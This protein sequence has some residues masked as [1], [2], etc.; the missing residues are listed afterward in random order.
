MH[1]EVQNHGPGI[2]PICGMALEP[3]DLSQS[4]NLPNEELIDMTRRFKLSLFF[5][6]PLLVW[7]MSEMW[8]QNPWASLI[9]S[10]IG[11][12]LQ[13]LLATPVVFG[14]GLPIFK[15]FYESLR[16]KN[17]NMFTLIG[18]GTAMA[19]LY[20]LV[21]TLAPHLFPVN[22]HAHGVYFESAAVITT[23]VLLGQVLELRAR[24]KTTHAIRGFLDLTPP[25]ATRLLAQGG[26]EQAQVDLL[27]LGD[28]VRIKPGERIPAD[29]VVITGNS[30]VDESMISGE[31]IPVEKIAGSS[32]TAGTLNGNGSFTFQV[33]RVGKN[34]LLA[35][36]IQIVSQAQRSRPPIQ[37]V[38]D[39]VSYYFV[40]AVI[41]IALLTCIV[42]W[43]W[44]PEPRLAHSLIPAVCVLIIACPCALGLAT[45]M[46]IMVGSGKAAQ[47]GV[48][49]KNAEAL[50][51]LAQ[52][53]ILILDKTGTLT[54][55]KPKVVEII[56]FP[57][58]DDDSILTL[59]ASVENQSEHPLAGAIVREAK[60]RKLPFRAVQDF[61]ADPGQGIQGKI[62]GKKILIGNLPY[63]KKEKIET[64]PFSGLLKNLI[65]PSTRIFISVDGKAAGILSLA[66][67]IKPG[68]REVITALHERGVTS[69]I[70][71]GD[72]EPTVAAVAQSLGISRFQGGLLPQDKAQFIN[73]LREQGHRVAMAGDGINDAPALVASDVGIAMSHGSDLAIE[74]AAITLLNKDVKGLLKAHR[75]SQSTLKNIHQNLFFALIYNA[76]GILIATGMLFPWFGVLLN[77]MVASAAMSLSSVSVIANSL[78]LKKAP[79]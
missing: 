58:F 59:A 31:P 72:Q 70:L 54:E 23:L 60:E 2:C 5:T 3:T 74:S 40:P 68:T 27:K 67:P 46:S 19:Y 52:I 32:V 55:G 29:G 24:E 12:G 1:P 65:Q 10:P 43:L 13:L 47:N 17:P 9:S 21:A 50:E 6:L 4:L 18:I 44:G 34:T 20:S 61:K 75:L 79:L 45:P 16:T 28:T 69:I 77:P 71:S 15:R 51:R 30:S 7:T 11:N 76:V 63:L 41:G 62:E 42:W 53:D 78:R 38:A 66:D 35:Q 64:E 48:L 22:T 8:P 49:V 36:I 37:R 39:K 73:K 26:E 33:T 14:C 56:P 25:F 57:P